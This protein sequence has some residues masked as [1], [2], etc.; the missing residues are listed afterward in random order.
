MSATVFYGVINGLLRDA[1]QMGSR[2]DIASQS[3]AVQVALARNAVPL[4]RGCGEFLEGGRQSLIVQS[5]W[6]KALAH[7]AG[8]GNCLVEQASNL[9]S[10]FSFLSLFGR[11]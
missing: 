2:G 6:I 9:P 4:G 7:G 3:L 8:L 11:K 5:N 1:V 10:S